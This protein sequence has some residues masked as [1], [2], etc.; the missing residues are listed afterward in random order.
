[1]SSHLPE[2]EWEA[3]SRA[4]QQ[5][6]EAWRQT[7]PTATLDEIETVIDA[8]L[9][10]VRAKLVEATAHASPRQ[11]WQQG[12]AVEQPRCARCGTPLAPRGRHRRRLQ[13]TGGA[14]IDLERTYGLC[15]TCGQGLFPPG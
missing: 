10:P 14:S 7:H 13:T 11:N 2:S 9:A 3:L 12:E 8:Q 6:I 1:M 5:T 4:L 15:P